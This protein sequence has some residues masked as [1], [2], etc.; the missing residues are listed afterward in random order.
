M[1][2]RHFQAMLLAAA[3]MFTVSAGW[4][5]SAAAQSGGR[6]PTVAA[7]ASERAASVYVT[8]EE[9]IARLEAALAKANARLAALEAKFAQHTHRVPGWEIGMVREKINGRNIELAF[10]PRRTAVQSG[11][12]A[13]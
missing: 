9:R 13:P 4:T 2:T 10:G 7:Q 3:L 5:R 1:S 8:P 12:P 6:P 11:P